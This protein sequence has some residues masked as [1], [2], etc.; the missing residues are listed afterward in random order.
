MHIN[1]LDSLLNVLQRP[2]EWKEDQ[3][4]LEYSRM[5]LRRKEIKF[6]QPKGWVD[7][8]R[9]SGGVLDNTSEMFF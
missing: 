6:E 9:D 2:I 3:S 5:A 1:T 8:G 4:G 7:V